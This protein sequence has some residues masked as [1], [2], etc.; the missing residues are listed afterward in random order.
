[1][2]AAEK[3]GDDMPPIQNTLDCQPSAAAEEEAAPVTRTQEEEKA[4]IANP[5]PTPPGPAPTPQLPQKSLVA[6]LNEVAEESPK[7]P[8]A[9]GTEDGSIAFV[10]GPGLA[11]GIQTTAEA[12][13]AKSPA[14]KAGSAG[15]QAT[16]SKEKDTGK[17]EDDSFAEQQADELPAKSAASDKIAS[18]AV[19]DSGGKQVSSAENKKVVGAARAESNDK[20][21]DQSAPPTVGG[22]EASHMAVKEPHSR[23]AEAKGAKGSTPSGA[24]TSNKKKRAGADRRDPFIGR[25]VKKDFETDDGLKTY[26]G[27]VIGKH[28]GKKW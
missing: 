6:T 11:E 5:T 7:L 27:W 20:E 17:P 24:A 15:T 16:A 10:T 13:G 3:E 1:M 21:N 8:Q 22:Q 23:V 25:C 2:P 4:A 9:V 26:T 28:P 12:A 14:G 19:T 18:S